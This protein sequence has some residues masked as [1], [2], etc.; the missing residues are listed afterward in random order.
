MN[1]YW[2]AEAFG[3]E[4]TSRL[5][6]QGGDFTW[7]WLDRKSKSPLFPGPGEAVVTIDWCITSHA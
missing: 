1:I 6:P 3:G 2:G 7:D 4:F 5:S